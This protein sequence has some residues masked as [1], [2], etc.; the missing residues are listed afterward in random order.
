[1]ARGDGVQV[2]DVGG[3]R[4]RVSEAGEGV[5]DHGDA[6]VGKHGDGGDVVE[7]AVGSFVKCGPDVC[8]GRS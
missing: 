4:G 8:G 2:V 7:G 1:M 5:Q 3:E 6:V